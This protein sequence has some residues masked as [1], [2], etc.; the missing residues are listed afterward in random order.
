MDDRNY[1]KHS[2]PKQQAKGSLD[3]RSDYAYGMI[4]KARGLRRKAD[5]ASHHRRR[6]MMREEIQQKG[7]EAQPLASTTCAQRRRGWDSRSGSRVPHSISNRKETKCHA[8]GKSEYSYCR[9]NRERG[10]F[11]PHRKPVSR[12]GPTNEAIMFSQSKR[13]LQ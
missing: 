2:R 10:A 9:K 11:S 3:A 13:D 7:A 1:L 8:S 4:D 6:Q 12:Y 5:R